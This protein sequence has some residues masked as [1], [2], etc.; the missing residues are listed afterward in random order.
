[1]VVTEAM[2][3]RARLRPFRLKAGASPPSP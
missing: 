2:G 3:F 1:L